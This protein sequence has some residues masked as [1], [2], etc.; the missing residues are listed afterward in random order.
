MAE[1]TQYGLIHLRRL[2]IAA[3]IEGAT[4]LI[5]VCVAVPLKHFANVPV[6]VSVMG[7]L[8]GM[9]FLVYLWM[10]FSAVSGQSWTWR[11]VARLLIGALIPFGALLNLSVLNQK[12]L[13]FSDRSQMNAAERAP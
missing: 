10:V 6:V 1:Q 9:A 2:R 5:L 13:K 8:H 12:V 3:L 4:L 11:E 7:P